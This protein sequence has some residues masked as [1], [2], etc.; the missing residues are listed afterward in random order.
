MRAAC[1]ACEVATARIYCAADDAKLCMRCDRTVRDDDDD[2]DDDDATR[3][4][5]TPAEAM[6]ARGHFFE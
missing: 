2:D 1:V 6:R 3:P 4:G 5:T